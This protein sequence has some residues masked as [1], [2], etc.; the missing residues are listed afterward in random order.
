LLPEEPDGTIHITETGC[1]LTE[2][3][4]GNK[5]TIPGE[6]RCL[7]DPA[8]C[9][10]YPLRTGQK[11]RTAHTNR[12]GG[13]SNAYAINRDASREDSLGRGKELRDTQDACTKKKKKKKRERERERELASAR[14]NRLLNIVPY[15][16]QSRSL[17]THLMQAKIKVCVTGLT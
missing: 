1:K 11:T 2:D 6:I 8:V 17:E 16:V 15:L 3:D 12:A 10:D 5:D 13:L 9:I 4:S 7:H 14:E